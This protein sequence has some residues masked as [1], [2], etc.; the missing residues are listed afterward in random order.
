[1][2]D[3]FFE[4]EV[5]LKPSVVVGALLGASILLCTI[6]ALTFPFSPPE[7]V[8]PHNDFWIPLIRSEGWW[9]P[10]LANVLGMP[11]ATWTILPLGLA[12][13]VSLFAV[14]RR[15][16][17]PGYF[18]AGFAIAAVTVFTYCLVPVGTLSQ[19]NYLKRAAIAERFFKPGD[20]LRKIGSEAAAG[21]WVFLQKVTTMNWL[22]S[23]ARSY[24]P[25]DFPY[26]ADRTLM[27]S[28]GKILKAAMEDFESGKT[29]EAER[30]LTLG[31][32]Q[33]PFAKCVFSTNLAVMFFESDRKDLAESK[34]EEV[35]PLVNP[36]SGANCIRSQY[37]LG[38][39]FR[40][41]GK[42]DEA[43]K[44]FQNFL[45]NSE[46]TDDPQLI[47]FRDQLKGN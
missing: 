20:R 36:A 17:R 11:S 22:I 15:V 38:S 21:D 44:L 6:P 40:E 23:D 43:N 13:G 16:G 27:P 39:L 28:A 1:M 2:L 31:I 34:L 26:M 30:T 35:Q 41:Q 42:N 12:F 33:Y 14:I 37:L 19:D 32:D 5:D 7:F 18:I 29:V 9:V 4:G 47:R 3:P 24:A 45:S 8:F 10:N 25:D 46:G